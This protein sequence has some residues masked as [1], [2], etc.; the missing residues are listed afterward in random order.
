MSQTFLLEMLSH[1]SR[2]VI[3]LNLNLQPPQATPGTYA[4]FPSERYM[5][6][7]E[8]STSS[9]SFALHTFRYRVGVNLREA[10][11]QNSYIGMWSRETVSA[12]NL[13]SDLYI[14]FPG[15]PPPSPSYYIYISKPP[16]E[17]LRKTTFPRS[18]TTSMPTV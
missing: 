8:F 6:F 10:W 5:R 12:L 11:I 2:Y 14:S 9:H 18:T 3:L 16:H 7:H 1:L 4:D 13:E 17:C 15:H